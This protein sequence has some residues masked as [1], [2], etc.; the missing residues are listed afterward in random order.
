MDIAYQKSKLQLSFV[1]SISYANMIDEIITFLFTL[2]F[3]G[4]SEEEQKIPE[5]T[6]PR[7]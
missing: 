3:S 5:F 6:N 4:H 1:A 2:L 7:F